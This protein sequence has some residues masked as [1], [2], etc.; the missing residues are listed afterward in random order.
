MNEGPFAA[1]WNNEWGALVF[2]V[3]LLGLA[4]VCFTRAKKFKFCETAEGCLWTI[5]GF[6]LAIGATVYGL[7]GL[8]LAVG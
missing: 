1:L 6:V 5:L 2:A 8:Q 4:S 7:R 3:V